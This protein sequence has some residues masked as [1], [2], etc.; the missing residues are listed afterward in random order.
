MGQTHVEAS[1]LEDAQQLSTRH[2][3]SK[4]RDFPSNK[5]SSEGALAGG[6]LAVARKRKIL[7]DY[8][9]LVDGMQSMYVGFRGATKI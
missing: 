1:V 9:D 8:D 6:V 5:S 4:A 3:D 2:V 7:L